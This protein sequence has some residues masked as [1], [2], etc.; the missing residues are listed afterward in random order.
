[1]RSRGTVANAKIGPD[2]VNAFSEEQTSTRVT[3]RRAK[4]QQVAGIP[5]TASYQPAESC[6]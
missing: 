4:S 1:M 5:A 3:P 2:L 6:E